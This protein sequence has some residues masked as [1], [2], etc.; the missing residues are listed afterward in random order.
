MEN[1]TP[2]V[3][4]CVRLAVPDDFAAL[5]F[6]VD[7]LMRADRDR[8]HLVRTSVERGECFVVVDDDEVQGFVILNYTLFGT[9][10][11]LLLVVASGD[12]WC[13]P[14]TASLEE[15][16]RQCVRSKFHLV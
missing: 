9:P 11:S 13:G 10:S 5:R 3:T 2:A 15:A 4:H 1:Q 7:P 16:E 14:A 6:I 12:R 8:Q